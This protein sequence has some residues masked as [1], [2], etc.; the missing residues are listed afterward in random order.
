MTRIA[1]GVAAVAFA[2]LAVLPAGAA[3]RD[4]VV[5][6][7]VERSVTVSAGDTRSLRLA[8]P[9]TAV[10]L[11][12]A[13]VEPPRGVIVRDS[14]PG[15]QARRWTFRLAAVAGASEREVTGVVRCVRLRLPARVSDVILRVSSEAQPDRV[16][17]AGQS[18]RIGPRC[19]RGYVP[20]GQGIG[21]SSR[22]VSVAAA[23]PNARGWNFRIENTG[24]SDATF[25]ARIRCLQR[26]VIGSRRNKTVRLRF[27]VQ[28]TAFRRT[29]AAGR[30][31]GFEGFCAGDHFSL[32]TGISLGQ[33]HDVQLADSYPSGGSSARWSFDQVR[34]AES[35]RAYM[36]CVARF[37]RFG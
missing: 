13:L 3:A 21:A 24:S 33:D 36:L 19:P 27:D 10:A 22:D 4:T 28:R 7:S 31:P 20:T 14:I 34:E 26:T 1:C 29:V 35:V 37:S 5:A 6:S 30:E 25:T 16:V 23:I 17:S 15:A 11:N 12:A 2:A 8:C 9:E 18:V 32:A